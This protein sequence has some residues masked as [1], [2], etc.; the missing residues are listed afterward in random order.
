MKF[1]NINHN[2]ELEMN[3]QNKMSLPSN[4]FY[5]LIYNT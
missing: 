1:E 4:T 2:S 5:L 3:Q